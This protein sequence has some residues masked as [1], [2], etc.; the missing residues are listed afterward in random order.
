[1]TCSPPPEPRSLRDVTGVDAFLTR[2]EY[3]AA[4]AADWAHPCVTPRG[5]RILARRSGP[6][7]PHTR[8]YLVT[9]Q[10]AISGRWGHPLGMLCGRECEHALAWNALHGRPKVR[11][12]TEPVRYVMD[13]NAPPSPA[14]CTPD[15]HAW[16]AVLLVVLLLGG[17]MLGAVLS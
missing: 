2:D 17:L 11:C 3:R 12:A 14:C 5:E 6:G 15:H 8:W 1:M 9:P 7:Q 16:I 13:E 4:C 10:E